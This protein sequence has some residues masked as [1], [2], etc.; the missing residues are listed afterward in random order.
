MLASH[1]RSR[2]PIKCD[3][4]E[5]IMMEASITCADRIRDEKI[6]ERFGIAPIADNL[7]ETCLRWYAHVL[8]ANKTLS[9]KWASISKY[10]ESN[11]KGGRSNCG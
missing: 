11:Q 6:R 2:T 1:Q 5:D 10:R 3:G 8:R 4:D 7:R 9:V